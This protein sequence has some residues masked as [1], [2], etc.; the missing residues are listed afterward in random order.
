METVKIEQLVHGG[1]G[2]ATLAD[3]RRVFV[4]NALPGETVSIRII[5][6]KHS[7]AEAIAEE[8][9][10]ASAERVEPREAN[11]LATSPWQMMTF[12][13]ENHNKQQIVDE[14]FKREKVN[15]PELSEVITNGQDW[16]YRNK[17]EY[18]FWG[19]ND[20]IHLALYRRGT[21]GKEIVDGSALALPAVDKAAR[22]VLDEL[23]S[24]EGIRAGDLKS[25]VVRAS[26][27]GKAVAA[28]FVRPKVFPK[29]NLSRDLQGFKLC[30][31]NPRSP[32]AVATKLLY[33]LGDCQLTDKIM[34]NDFKYD[35]D[36]FFQVNIP[37]FEQALAVIKSN[38]ATDQLTDMYSGT[39]VIGLSV[40]HMQVDLVELDEASANMA[41][42]NASHSKIEAKVVQASAEKVLDYIK[43][44]RPV[45]FDPPRAGLHDKVVE[46]V[47][48]VKPGQ[49]IY[50]SCNPATQARDLAKLQAIYDIEHFD[51]FNFFPKTPHIET[52]AV[53]R[54]R[55]INGK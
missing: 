18:S 50:L 6:D 20:G 51:I 32:A 40:A 16:N 37:V 12:A 47:L 17:M 28:L 55:A 38:I 36:S 14:L 15:L 52:L 42:E 19:D 22:A 23:N 9:V 46:R 25:M 34:G 41:K 35:V 54:L 5:K 21:H 11:Y 8:V 1:Q 33:T 30:H 44:D 39:G 10:E 27:S 31:S 43:S 45:I 24:L 13:A 53:L 29:I 4:W 7:Y 2:L 3:G 48:E 49:V 26:A